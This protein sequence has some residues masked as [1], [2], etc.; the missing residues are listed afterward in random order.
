[1]TTRSAPS[2]TWH[3][4]I[5]APLLAAPFAF[6]SEVHAQVS[7]QNNE[8]AL[9]SAKAA[10]KRKAVKAAAKSENAARDAAEKAPGNSDPMNVGNGS[11]CDIDCDL[12][13]DPIACRKRFFQMRR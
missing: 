2:R 13:S 7:S 10:S 8:K 11:I 4:L 12:C 1:M 5:L 3:H 9:S 6:P